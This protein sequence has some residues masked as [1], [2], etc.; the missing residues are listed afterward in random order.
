MEFAEDFIKELELNEAQVGAISKLVNENEATLKKEWDSLANENAEKIIEGAG[1]KVIEL[2]GIQRNQG[3]KWASYLER[4]NDGYFEGTKASLDRKIKELNE[5]IKTSGSDETLKKEL[6]EAKADIDRLKK[7][8][9]EHDEFVKGDYKNLFEKTSNELTDTK[10][11]IAWSLVKPKFA[12]SVNVYEANAKW[13]DFVKN[14]ES[15][16]EITI[17]NEDQGFAVDKENKYKSKKLEELV[18]EDQSLQGLIN[19]RQLKG[20]G[21]DG[22]TNIKIEGVPFDVPEK[23]T[24]QERQKAIRDYLA[25]DQKLSVTDPKYSVQFA[26]LNKKILEKTPN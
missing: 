20:L 4:A 15:K 17:D 6:Q 18:K 19:G 23:A 10:R 21:I 14:I 5:K 11:K 12:D 9:A 1:K 3:E 8:E 13:N 24:P 16:Y 7:I 26:E 2:T 25:N 22:K